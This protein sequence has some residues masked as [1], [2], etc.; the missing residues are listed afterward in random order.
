M[1]LQRL[2]IF[3]LILFKKGGEKCGCQFHRVA[4]NIPP[5]PPSRNS[6][7]T[8]FCNV[9][10]ITLKGCT[11]CQFQRNPQMPYDRRP[12]RTQP[13]AYVRQF[14]MFQ[15]TT[16]PVTIPP[17]NSLSGA[18]PDWTKVCEELCSLGQGGVLCKCDLPPFF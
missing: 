13:P 9:H 11:K 12:S 15:P 6:I 2:I 1:E 7:C 18:T 10:H 4:R 17:I 5:E 16:S 3:L 14:I 8:S